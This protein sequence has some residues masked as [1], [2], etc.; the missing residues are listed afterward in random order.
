MDHDTVLTI[1]S[2]VPCSFYTVPGIYY[3][4]KGTE[5]KQYSTVLG[6]MKQDSNIIHR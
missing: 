2:L 6:R 1:R 3:T 4:A 5:Q